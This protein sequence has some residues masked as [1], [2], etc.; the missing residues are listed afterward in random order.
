MVE[1][2]LPRKLRIAERKLISNKHLE[3]DLYTLS[4]APTNPDL[5]RADV[6][7]MVSDTT[8]DNLPIKTGAKLIESRSGSRSKSSCNPELWV[9]GELDRGHQFSAKSRAL[10]VLLVYSNR[11]QSTC[12]CL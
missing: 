8:L 1:I 7:S 12:S 5:K 2:L 4:G 6:F 3:L 10:Y 11:L 9:G